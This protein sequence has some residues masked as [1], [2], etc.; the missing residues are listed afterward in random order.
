MKFSI[1]D[2][3]WLTALIAVGAG[4]WVDRQSAALKL[5]HQ[6][7]Q[8]L[9]QETLLD[10]VETSLSMPQV[11]V[12]Q[13]RALVRDQRSEWQRYFARP[14]GPQPL[15]VAPATTPGQVTPLPANLFI[16]PAQKR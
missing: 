10:T 9:Q 8:L 5:D 13:L 14:A 3:L 1:R 12:D 6:L 2:V 15:I 16:P 7:R 4:W 11:D